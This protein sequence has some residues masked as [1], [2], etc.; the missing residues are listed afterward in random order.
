M[1]S[2]IRK[3]PAFRNFT[4]KVLL[5][6]LDKHP[7][8]PYNSPMFK[9]QTPT[10]YVIPVGRDHTIERVHKVRSAGQRETVLSIVNSPDFDFACMNPFPAVFGHYT[11]EFMFAY[12]TKDGAF[13]TTFIGRKG[14]VLFERLHQ[15]A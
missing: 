8:I 1:E 2:R 7:L 12:F 14:E 6:P 13:H 15:G 9:T 4:P 10:P 3:D 11:G 5:K